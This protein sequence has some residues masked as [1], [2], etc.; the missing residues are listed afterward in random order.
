MSDL[1]PRILV[2]GANGQL[3]RLVLD[4][5]LETMPAAQLAAMVRD[6]DSAARLTAR[7]VQ[8]RIAD[9]AQPETLDAALRGVQRLLLISS[10][11]IGQ[12]ASQHRN[13]IAAAVRAGVTLIAY[14]SVLHA[15]TTPL[16]LAEEHRETEADLAASGVPFVLLRNGWYTENLT[17]FMPMALAHGAQLGSAGAGRLSTASRADYADA[18]VAVLAA[19]QGQGGRVYELAGDAAF[20]LREYAAEVSRQSGKPVEYNNLPEAEFK[21][22]LVGAGL[23]EPLAAMLADADTGAAKGALFDEGHQLS[24]LI[25][26]RTTP[27]AATVTAALQG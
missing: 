26:H 24:S 12:R 18:A 7:G 13:V 1:Q 9:Y 11:A 6:P 27:L 10:N 23:P 5:L 8:A 20:S 16:G 3:G 2:T 15:D 14:T 25:G 21:A 17:A 22:A 4:K 19:Q